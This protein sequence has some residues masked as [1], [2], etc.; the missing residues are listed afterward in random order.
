MGLIRNLMTLPRNLLP[1]NEKK[2]ASFALVN[3]GVESQSFVSGK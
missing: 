2:V 1:E 3:E